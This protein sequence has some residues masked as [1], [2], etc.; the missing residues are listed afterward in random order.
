MKAL[1]IRVENILIDT[2][3]LCQ[4]L[5]IFR[6]YISKIPACCCIGNRLLP[7]PCSQCH[8]ASHFCLLYMYIYS[9]CYHK[10]DIY[11]CRRYATA[12]LTTKDVKLNWKTLDLCQC[13]RTP[14]HSTA[15]TGENSECEKELACLVACKA[16]RGMQF[17]F[18]WCPTSIAKLL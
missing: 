10:T 17:C 2:A 13:N 16:I 11:E 8:S 15:R 7:W 1:H 14:K 4:L 6:K 18:D 5:R 3:D 9:V 12:T